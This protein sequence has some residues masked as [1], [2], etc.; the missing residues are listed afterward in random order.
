MIKTWLLKQISQ[1]SGEVS[2]KV[3]VVRRYVANAVN[4]TFTCKH[5]LQKQFFIYPHEGACVIRFAFIL[6]AVETVPPLAM[7]SLVVV[8]ELHLPNGLKKSCLR[9]LLGEMTL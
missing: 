2:T 1:S 6:N 4:T 7:V 3:K 9:K 8:V 5:L